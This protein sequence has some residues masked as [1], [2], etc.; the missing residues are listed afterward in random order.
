MRISNS[1][2]RQKVAA[3]SRRGADGVL[4]KVGSFPS[5][6]RPRSVTIPSCGSKI[7]SMTGTI[8]QISASPGAPAPEG[9]KAAP[10]RPQDGD[11]EPEGM[12]KWPSL[13][14]PLLEPRRRL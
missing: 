9:P 12:G 10:G 7:V 3:S 13:R 8:R 5:R 2:I 6:V 14:K 1:I 4:A 11:E